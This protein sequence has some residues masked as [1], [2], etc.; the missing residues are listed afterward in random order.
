VAGRWATFEARVRELA[1]NIHSRPCEP[2]RIGGVNIDGVVEIDSG[3]LILIEMTV[4]RTLEKVREDIGKLTIAKMALAAN[5]TFAECYCILNGS[6]T[7]AMFD[8]GK[9]QHI[10]V[11]DVESFS[12]IFFD[13]ESYRLVR[14]SA[15]F[16]SAVNP[17]TGVKDDSDYVPVKYVSNSSTEE[18]DTRE[19]SQLIR[20]GKRIVLLGEYGTGK[21]R[22]LREIFR[23][24]SQDAA[25]YFC[26]PV[27][28]DLRE[29][30]GLKRGTEL[31][32]RHLE[33]LALD[34]LQTSAIA[35][36]ASGSIAF[37]IDGFDEIGSQAWS[38]DGQKLRWIRSQALQGIKDLLQR[39]PGGVI[40]TG[41]GHYFSTNEEMFSAL[42]LSP[43][44]TIV[45][46]CKGEFSMEEL[47]EFFQ[48][49]GINVEIPPWL[50]K[51]PLICQTISNLS[52]D[53]LEQMFGV[54]EGEVDFWNHLIRVICE[55]D[56]RIHVSFDAST[57]QNVL[58][59]LARLTRSRPANVGP[60]SLADNQQ[61]FEAAVGQMPVEEAALMLQRLPC[62]GRLSAE[63]NDRQ[64]V[65][66]YILDGLRAKDV[67][68]IVKGDDLTAR[69]VADSLWINPLDELGQRILHSEAADLTKEMIQFATKCLSGNNRVLG[70]DIIATMLRGDDDKAFDFKGIAVDQGK[71]LYFDMSNRTPMNLRVSNSY[72]TNLILPASAPPGT[73][74]DKCVAERVFG[75][76][77]VAGLPGWISN[78]DAETYDSVDNVARIR[79]AGLSPAHQVL[80]TVIK[81]TF[82]QKGA[83]RMEEAL[84]RGLGQIVPPNVSQKIV[85]ILVREDCLEK[86]K[87]KEGWVFSPRRSHASSLDFSNERGASGLRI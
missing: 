63:T 67:L 2:R 57:I 33:D 40:I 55:R 68:T 22:C 82:F 48:K 3:H 19:I 37:L 49:R 78:L 65:D 5:G 73:R 1:A 83:G 69:I 54:G 60:I 86:F 47:H 70:A 30:W 34:R 81:K 28:I 29:A 38:N 23:H 41:R 85:N 13:F 11:F 21:S 52:S 9:P 18:F 44:Q 17:T 50:P 77:S 15:P 39:T 76:A 24:L 56:A 27:A 46:R 10:K 75:V 61:A 25:K 32:R 31:V 66:E 71:F 14:D 8:A 6:I 79:K 36:L 51:R 74:I 20:T 72:F 59:Y 80:V 58:T 64:F 45:L 87:G 35:A 4:N 7:Q 53:D 42:G 12:R 16:G 84:L 26:Y 62:L 43:E